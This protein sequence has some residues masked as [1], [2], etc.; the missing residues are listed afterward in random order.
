MNRTPNQQTQQPHTQN[1]AEHNKAERNKIALKNKTAHNNKASR[2]ETAKNTKRR[3]V[4]AILLVASLSFLGILTETSLNVSFP[5]LSREFG[6]PLNMVQ[7]LTSG[8]LLMIAIIMIAS[9]FLN[10]R[11]TAR[12]LFRF[13]AIAFLVGSLICILSTNF[14]VLLTG[15]LLT[16]F[17]AGLTTPLMFNLVTELM[18]VSQRGYWMGVVGLV[19]ALAPSLGP[20]F[21]GVV[22]KLW[23][24]RMV[25]WIVVTL[26][27]IILIVGWK[28]VGKY[29]SIEHPPFDWGRF[30]VAA[31]AMA[32]FLIGFNQLSGGLSNPIFWTGLICSLILIFVFIWMS[33]RSTRLLFDVSVLRNQRFLLAL[34]A[35]LLLQSLNI[36]MSFVLPS[37]AQIVCGFSAMAGGL[38]LLPGSVIPSLCNPWFGKL[39]DTYG[40]RL[41][42]FTGAGFL[43]AGTI[44]FSCFGMHLTLWMMICFYLLIQIG[45]RISFNNTMT[46]A[47][48]VAAPER[49]ADATA[50]L[51]TAQQYAGSIGTTVLSTIM[52]LSQRQ[53]S[54]P[55]DPRYVALTAQ[56]ATH[57]FIFTVFVAATIALLYAVLLLKKNWRGPVPEPKE[58][59]ESL[60]D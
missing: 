18:P 60:K 34:F 47:I 50:V 14:P 25:F 7:W 29:H 54:G 49:H 21:G 10:R 20:T 51:Q 35:Y 59:V 46:E 56:G 43:L 17:A 24:W 37:Y 30:V 32:S 16:A 39:Y 48:A 19:V 13:G 41:P 11:F 42:L 22:E 33:R 44:L 36:G 26:C 52:A 27:A 23:G 9:S 15:R 55:T 40:P 53:A 3:N 8:Y 1:N 58:E 4:T 57:A 6:V 2:G 45:H 12:A 38:I 31:A 28:F 5:V